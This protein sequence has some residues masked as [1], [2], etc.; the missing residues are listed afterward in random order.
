M[1]GL[2]VLSIHPQQPSL[3]ALSWDSNVIVSIS[4]GFWFASCRVTHLNLS[5]T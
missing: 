4:W 3:G 2:T 5:P 1:G